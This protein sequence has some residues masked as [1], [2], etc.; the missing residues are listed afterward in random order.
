[1]LARSDSGDRN[2]FLAFVAKHRAPR[3]SAHWAFLL[4]PLKLDHV[5]PNATIRYRQIE[6]YRMPV[7]GLLALDEPRSGVA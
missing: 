2:K 5:D 3:I 4:K 7:M 1:M 6:F